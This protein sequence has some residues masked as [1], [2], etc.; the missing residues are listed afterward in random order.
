MAL[1]FFT[2]HTSVCD[3]FIYNQPD[4]CKKEIKKETEFQNSTNFIFRSNF[5][6]INGVGYLLTNL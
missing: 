6:S 1:A 3:L 4:C 2:T 5:R